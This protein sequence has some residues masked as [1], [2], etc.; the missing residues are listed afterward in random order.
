MLEV[1]LRV[2]RDPDDIDFNSIWENGLFVFDS[3]VLLD[4]YRLPES[5]SNDLIGVL[6]DDQLRQ[7][8]WIGF[9]VIVEF[10]NNRHEAISDQKNKF[11]TVRS[12]LEEASNQYDEVFEKLADD[13]GKLKLKQRH[14]LIDP[15]KFITPAKIAEGK[16]LIEAFLSE[17]SVLESKQSDV[18]DRDQIKDVVLEIFADKV[19]EGFDRKELEEIYKAGEKRYEN[20]VP[21]GYKDKSKQG[22]YTVEDKELIRKYGD[23]ILWK[24]IVRKAKADEITSVV[25][26]TGDIKE[27]WWLEK[28]GKK[29]GPRKEL[30]NEIY[31][32]A[33]CVQ[34]FYM[35]DTASFLKHAK[36]RLKANVKDSSITQAKNLI[37]KTRQSRVVAEEGYIFVP[38]CI[39][40]A[41]SN[42]LKLRVGIGRSVH[43]LPPVRL[44]RANLFRCLCEIF[45]N[46][47]EHGVHE[48]IGAQAKDRE[49]TIL[50][51]FKN[52]VS[53][54]TPIPQVESGQ[55]VSS[56]FRGL[57]LQDVHDLMSKEGVSVSTVRT[58]KSFT[59]EL[60]IPKSKFFRD[61]TLMPG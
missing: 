27:D 28:R 61:A 3:N 58:E 33:P 60:H 45:S 17:L 34:T 25:L 1:L 21:P 31:T 37:E 11:N 57:G 36:S 59:V 50:L 30:L 40:L 23:L 56:P 20:N 53:P 18:N 6:R 44:D 35:Y 43:N 2:H 12:L 46:A 54:N 9:Q 49:D 41:A 47:I 15:D 52:K 24:E 16:S 7:R 48:Y 26:V 5:A 14:S 39:K 4:L 8:I 38:E 22:S 19:G 13:L 32:E 42:I 10:L 29:L 55:V 51:R